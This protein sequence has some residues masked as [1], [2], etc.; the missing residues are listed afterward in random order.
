MTTD[1]FTLVSKTAFNSAVKKITAPAFISDIKTISESVFIYA[2]ADSGMT[3]AT[4]GLISVLKEHATNIEKFKALRKYLRNLFIAA[5]YEP[6]QATN[7]LN[8]IYSTARKNGWTDPRVAEK[9]DGVGKKTSERNKID[10]ESPP[11]IKDS[12]VKVLSK[13]GRSGKGVTLTPLQVQAGNIAPVAGI[14]QLFEL[15]HNPKFAA[16]LV[17]TVFTNDGTLRAQF[18]KVLEDTE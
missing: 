12:S 5:G 13:G 3:A 4:Q 10:P 6:R 16:H 11:V 18:R 15:L 17:N 7:R 1:L 9:V 2:K 14:E 8:Y